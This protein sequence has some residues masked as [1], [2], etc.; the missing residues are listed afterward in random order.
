MNIEK[1]RSEPG[2]PYNLPS[3]D[4]AWKQGLTVPIG[5][6]TLNGKPYLYVGE[7][8]STK[9][10]EIYIRHLYGNKDLAIRLNKEDKFILD[11]I[12]CEYHKLYHCW[13]ESVL[14][15]MP[16]V[17]INPDRARDFG[18]KKTTIM[19]LVRKWNDHWAL[20][21]VRQGIFKNIF[22]EDYIIQPGSQ[23]HLF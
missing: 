18:I 15:D 2:F 3:Y 23:L 14:L 12:E 7:M 19:H 11:G 5:E 16:T 13:N 10:S 22:I 4:K 1:Y 6:F 21:R 8:S 9:K 17:K 20:I